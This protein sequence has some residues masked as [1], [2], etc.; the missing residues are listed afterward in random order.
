MHAAAAALQRPC[1]MEEFSAISR[2]SVPMMAFRVLNAAFLDARREAGL[3]QAMRFLATTTKI[4]E[5]KI[6]DTSTGYKGGSTRRRPRYIRPSTVKG[7]VKQKKEKPKQTIPPPVSI[8]DEPTPKEAYSFGPKDMNILD[9][10]RNSTGERFYKQRVKLTRSL[11]KE[12]AR[13][14]GDRGRG[15]LEAIGDEIADI[16]NESLRSNKFADTFRRV[17]DPT[18]FIEIVKVVVN[19][20]LSHADAYWISPVIH[21]FAYS[22]R[23]SLGEKKEQALLK[24]MSKYINERLQTRESRFRTEVM[25]AMQFKRVPR[26]FFHKKKLNTPNSTMNLNKD[27]RNL[28]DNEIENS[29]LGEYDAHMNQD[30]YD[31]GPDDDLSTLSFSKRW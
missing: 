10:V 5:E 19:R 1:G 27:A 30:T 18:P 17:R 8:L 11:E 21:K 15:T 25:R 7:I 29:E 4:W 20:D 16:I 13:D 23:E 28:F 26:I 6:E 3:Q 22:C 14:I 31:Y 9:E 12:A 24:K 2:H